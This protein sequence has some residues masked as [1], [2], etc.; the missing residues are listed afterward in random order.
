[1]LL[2]VNAFNS[3][4]RIISKRKWDRILHSSGTQRGSSWSTNSKNIDAVGLELLIFSVKS[5]MKEYTN[6]S[7][8]VTS[9]AVN[10]IFFFLA[11]N[12]TQGHDLK[13]LG[14]FCENINTPDFF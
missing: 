1:M 10:V 3:H 6:S 5:K 11:G 2:R 9:F 8:N 13:D 7:G 4:A 12:Y 14:K